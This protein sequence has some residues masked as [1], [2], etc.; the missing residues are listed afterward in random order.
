M[1]SAVAIKMGVS[2]SIIRYQFL[3]RFR[4]AR[5]GRFRPG[6]RQR[7]ARYRLRLPAQ[8]DKRLLAYCSV[9]EMS[10]SS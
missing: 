7:P 4:Q 8:N 2:A 6:H 5:T 9:E 10:A 1:M 3:Y